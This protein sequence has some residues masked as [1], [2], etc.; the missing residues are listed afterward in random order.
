[1]MPLVGHAVL[2]VE[3]DPDVGDE[4]GRTIASE[5]G[6][7]VGPFTA[8]HDIIR[9]LEIGQITS[10]VLN[11]DVGQ[12]DVFV[13]AECL[14]ERRIPY[15][16]CAG[17]LAFGPAGLSGPIIFEPAPVPRLVAALGEIIAKAETPAEPASS[18]LENGHVL[19]IEDDPDTAMI[20]ESFLRTRGYGSF[21][22]ID[23]EMGAVIAVR[24]R[25]PDLVVADIRLEHGSGLAAAAVIS[26]AFGVPRIIVTGYPTAARGLDPRLV[27]PKPFT[28]DGL[29]R[30]IDYA[31]AARNQ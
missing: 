3:R 12:G 11:A 29:R 4:L 10:A 17:H 19:V 14:K 18:G 26:A 27:V 9:Y 6:I 24:R 22:H 1:M 20:L 8:A 15:L 13:I 21:E 16:V 31:Q 25:R 28:L 7:A 2:V 30:A 23:Y 5:G